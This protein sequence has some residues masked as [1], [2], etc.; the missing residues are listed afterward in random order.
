VTRMPDLDRP[1]RLGLRENLAQFSLLVLVNALVG[2]M[3]GIERT[4]VPLVGTAEFHIGSAVVVLSFIIA[5][6]LIKALLNLASGWLA[7]RFTRK[8]VLVACWI[9]GV[10][11]PFMLGW[12]PS[13]AWIVAANVLLG[14][15]QG[16]AWSMTVNMKIDRHSPACHGRRTVKDLAGSWTPGRHRRFSP[17]RWTNPGARHSS[18]QPGP[19]AGP[20][21]EGDIRTDIG[22]N[23][24]PAG[25]FP[26]YGVGVSD[27]PRAGTPRGDASAAPRPFS[28][29]A[30]RSINPL[31]CAPPSPSSFHKVS[32]GILLAV[33]PPRKS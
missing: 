14:I 33:L 12:G 15:S 5:F 16:L 10:P 1:V 24:A 26:R 31:D 23:F 27:V 28:P 11:V 29:A 18:L 20:R 8:S 19:S 30:K 7:D 9:V 3:V 32:S 6:G 22:Q 25:V 13:W 4:V 21:D 17:S 2:G